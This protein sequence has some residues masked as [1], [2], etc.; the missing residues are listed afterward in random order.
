[1]ADFPLGYLPSHQV[2][3]TLSAESGAT[4]CGAFD[5]SAPA[6]ASAWPASFRIM[7]VPLNLT[8]PFLVSLF[9]WA[10]GTSLNGEVEAGIYSKSGVRIAATGSVLQSGIATR[11][12]SAAPTIGTFLL[13]PDF[14][15]LALTLSGSGRI[16]KILG[17]LTQLRQLNVYE[18]TPGAFG[19]PATAT[20]GTNAS[21][22]YPVL[23]ISEHTVI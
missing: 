4:A 6:G 15:Y 16:Y 12:Q 19:L 11:T 3:S 5:F 14:Y 10:N 22:W 23:G 13:P 9:W 20:F 1:M 18:E 2:I 21:G 7:Y 8:H 17:T